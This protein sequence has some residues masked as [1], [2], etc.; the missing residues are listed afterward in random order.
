[1]YSREEIERNAPLYGEYGL[2]SDFVLPEDMRSADDDY[3]DEQWAMADDDPNYWVSTHGRIYSTKSNQFLKAKKMDK[4][5][6]VGFAIYR[7]GDKPKYN[8]LHR[9]MAKA[10]IPNPDNDPVVRHLTDDPDYNVIDNLAWGTQKDNMRDCI[11]NGNFYYPSDED[12]RKGN[13]DRLV[14]TFTIDVK[15]GETREYESL[16]EAVRATGVQQSNAWKVMNGKR[17]QTCGY[18]FRRAER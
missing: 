16:N 12:R 8:Y 10:F 3:A 18:I 15:T 4:H 5:G 13:A 11:E 17:K 2:Y 6:H 14:K 1:M 9:L 7:P